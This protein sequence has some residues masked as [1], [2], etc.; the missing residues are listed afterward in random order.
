MV[1]RWPRFN[2][3]SPVNNSTVPVCMWNHGSIPDRKGCNYEMENK[4]I[5]EYDDNSTSTH[6]APWVLFAREASA[7]AISSSGRM[8][9][10]KRRFPTTPNRPDTRREEVRRYILH[11]KGTIDVVHT[12]PVL[13]YCISSRHLILCS[14]LTD[15]YGDR[16]SRLPDSPLTKIKSK[17]CCSL[18]LPIRL[19]PLRKNHPRRREDTDTSY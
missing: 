16:S 2:W 4:N 3:D 8:N 10:R 1:A 15:T 12:V 14:I 6:L 13:L 7:C 18:L 19:P 17:R 11:P 5:V 9:T